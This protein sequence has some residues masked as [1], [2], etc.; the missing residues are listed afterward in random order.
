MRRIVLSKKKDSKDLLAKI[1]AVEIKFGITC[2]DKKNMA[3]VLCAG[4][5]DYARVMTVTK[6]ITQHVSKRWRLQGN[7]ESAH[8]KLEDDEHETALA[9][10]NENGEK[11]Y[12]CGS[13][14]HKRNKCPHQKQGGRNGNNG[15][16]N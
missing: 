5:R 16:R 7:K 1:L 14:H 11:C 4:R 12:K 8:K 10:V 15:G 6:T 13:P 2:T 3:V 9:D